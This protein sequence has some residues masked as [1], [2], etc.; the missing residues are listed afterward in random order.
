MTQ[1]RIVSIWTVVLCVLAGFVSYGEVVVHLQNPFY[2]PT[3][4]VSIIDDYDPFGSAWD[5]VHPV[6]GSGIHLNP[7]GGADGDGDPSLVYA[8]GMEGPLVVW[9][10]HDNGSYRLVYS[11]F[12]EG[13]W[14]APTAI[15]SETDNQLDPSIVRD[16]ADGSFHLVYWTDG[17]TPAVWYRKAPADLSSWSMAERVS[18]LTETALRPSV[19]VYADALYIAFEVH[20]NGLGQAPHELVVAKKQEG[21]MTVDSLGF[22]P[23]S[24]DHR[25][26]LRTI[27][28][29]IWAEWVDTQDEMCWRRL[30]TGGSWEPLQ[31]EGYGDALDREIHAP[32]RI[33]TQ[34][35][36]P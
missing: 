34:A 1:Q 29:R 5:P 15:A 30:S 17:P 16:P 23:A 18:G 21:V 35:L 25:I 3:I 20:L 8:E 12:L 6:G 4:V 7:T 31:I 32:G 22:S 27:S 2:N 9:A 26:E 36:V 24:V 13:A 10:D 33:R 11:Q 14:S 19:A 28:G